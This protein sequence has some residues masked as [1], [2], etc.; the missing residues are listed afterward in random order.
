MAERYITPNTM[1]LKVDVA[2]G[3]SYD[4]VVCLT[5]V[6]F[7]GSTNIIDANS[8]CGADKLAGI[9][10]AGE[11]SIEGIILLDPASGK[12]SLKGLYDAWV[13]KDIVGYEVSPN[14]PVA[15]DLKISGTAYISN[16]DI[17]LGLDE[18]QNF[19][20]TLTNKVIPTMTVHV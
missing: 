15:G 7:S 5:S 19:S 10:D 16:T 17:N 13:G 18:T 8:F 3:T 2:G 1:L 20:I 4:T 14:V 6:S 12:I 11:W 9:V